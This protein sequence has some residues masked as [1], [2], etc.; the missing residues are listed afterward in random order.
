MVRDDTTLI[1]TDCMCV[2]YSELECILQQFN[3]EE[4][5]VQQCSSSQSGFVVILHMSPFVPVWESSQFMQILIILFL[6][7]MVGAYK[8]YD[9][10]TVQ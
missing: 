2:N 5:L 7:G 10:P 3:C 8:F 6:V 1:I 9:F 4:I